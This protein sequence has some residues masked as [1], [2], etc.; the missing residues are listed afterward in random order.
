MR[1]DL[2]PTSILC[3]LNPIRNAG[4]YGTD[5]RPQRQLCDIIAEIVVYHVPFGLY[6]NIS[7]I[8]LKQ[9]FRYHER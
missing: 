5:S 3:L 7:C 8:C 1:L 9:A 2:L 6:L 4:V